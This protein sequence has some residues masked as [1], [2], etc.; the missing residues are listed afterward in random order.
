MST[1]FQSVS[2]SSLVALLCLVLS[3][4]GGHEHKGTRG[5]L[6]GPAMNQATDESTKAPESNDKTGVSDNQILIGSCSSLTGSA[7]FLGKQLITGARSYLNHVNDEGGVHERKIKL[8]SHDDAYDP[9]KAI[10]CFNCLLKEKVFAGAFFVGTPTA[11][12]HVPMAEAN[13]MPLVG[14][15]TGAQLLH[16][17]FRPHVISV[18]ASYYDE[19]REQVNNLWNTGYKKIAVIYQNDAFGAAVLNGVRLALE[20][21]GSAPIALGSFPRNTLDVDGSIQQVEKAHPDAVVLV[22]TYTP[23]AEILKR[24]HATGWRPRF[25]T[26]SFV[27]TEALIKAAGKDAE[28]VI[29]TQVV[30]PYNRDDLPTVVLYKQLLKK[31][32]PGEAPSFA[33]FEGF[34]DA[35]VLVEGLKEA[36]RELTRSK[37]ITAI[38]SIHNRDL[39]LGTN[40][41]LTYGPKRHKGFDSVYLTVVRDGQARSFTDWKELKSP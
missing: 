1:A 13:Q 40:F 24:S 6:L 41:K 18:R 29:I 12:K 28:G 34:V 30:P 5:Q 26:V 33:S 38:E 17:P 27:G 2:K 39:G 8:L 20:L 37:F 9:Q 21:H 23:L 16:E 7:S 11:A 31:Y 32:F 15:Y 36:G 4:C 25:L 10:E 22:G 3:A 19:T 14:L 35:M